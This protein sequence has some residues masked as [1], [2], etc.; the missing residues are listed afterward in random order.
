MTAICVSGRRPESKDCGHTRPRSCK[1]QVG[2]LGRRPKV[3]FCAK[4][5]LRELQRPDQL[6][7]LRDLRSTCSLSGRAAMPLEKPAAL[8]VGKSHQISQVLACAVG[9][10]PQLLRCGIQAVDPESWMAETSPSGRCRDGDT[11]RGRHDHCRSQS[12]V[13]TSS[14]ISL[15]AIFAAITAVPRARHQRA[16]PKHRWRFDLAGTPDRRRAL[17]HHHR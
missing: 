13:S 3:R 6:K 2:G 10:N 4:S 5:G 15:V 12:R 11:S 17:R 7:D 16:I 1:P 9:N 14:S 8:C